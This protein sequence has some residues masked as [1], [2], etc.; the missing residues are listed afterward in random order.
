MFKIPHQAMTKY[1]PV[2]RHVTGLMNVGVI[3][4]LNCF[5]LKLISIRHLNDAYLTN[6]VVNPLVKSLIC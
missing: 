3:G 5:F 2:L 6:T 1:P 4:I